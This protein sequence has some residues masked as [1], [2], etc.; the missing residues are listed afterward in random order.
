MT[1]SI[2][3]HRVSVMNNLYVHG[4]KACK[5]S[6]I[7]TE[8]DMYGGYKDRALRIVMQNRSGREVPVPKTFTC[9]G[10][11]MDFVPV[12]VIGRACAAVNSTNSTDHDPTAKGFLSGYGIYYFEILGQ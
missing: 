4:L 8:V 11:Q 10:V 2:V 9:D 1:P 3:L 7:D 6:G 5:F 12:K